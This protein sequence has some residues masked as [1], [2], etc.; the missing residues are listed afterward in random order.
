MDSRRIKALWVEYFRDRLGHRHLP[1]APLVPD[2]PT[3]LLTNAGMVPF[4]P[5]FLGYKEPPASRV[6]SVQRCVRV[7][8][9]DS[10]L[11]NIGKTSRHLSFFEMLGNFSFG[12]YFKEQA[13]PWAWELMTEVYG[14][15][16]QNLAASIFAGDDKTARD[17]ESYRIWREV[18]GLSSD[19]I[20]EMGRQDNF[21]GPPGTDTGPCGPCSEIHYLPPDGSPPVELWNLVFMEY[22]QLAD[23]SLSK[24]A[25]PNVDTGAGLERLATVLQG[26]TNVF[27]T[28][29]LAAVLDRLPNSQTEDVAVARRVIAD[30]VRCAAIMLSEGI[31]PGN[32]GR[33]YVLRMLIRRA[34]GLAGPWASG[35]PSWP[36]WWAACES[37]IR[38]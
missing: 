38:S 26:K 3:L 14:L 11:E 2:N 1:S 8:G 31:R 25:T 19:R 6:V 34:A 36:S 30:H 17:H 15:P 5:C 28:D 33:G 13:I 22:E 24:L 27:E 23:G 29:L 7:G 4:V 32:V 37:L 10:D 12:D 18:V 9:K 35:N 21:W 20:W 16:S